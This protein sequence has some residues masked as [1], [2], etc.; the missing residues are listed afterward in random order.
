[1]I[2]CWSAESHKRNNAA[3]VFPVL[4]CAGQN[5]GSMSCVTEPTLAGIGDGMA[6][7]VIEYVKSPWVVTLLTNRKS[8]LGAVTS[9]NIGAGCSFKKGRGRNPRMLKPQAKF[10]D[11]SVGLE[12]M[13]DNPSEA[14]EMR[15]QMLAYDCVAEVV[16]LE[17]P[18][19]ITLQ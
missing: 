18:N 19:W 3:L 16:V 14:E 17:E 5:A 13:T 2:L 6:S 10:H 1:M 12:F 15:E 4:P 9:G 11:G 7:G 8:F